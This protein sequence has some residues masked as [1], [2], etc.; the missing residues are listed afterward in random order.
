VPKGPATSTDWPARCAAYDWARVEQDLDGLGHARLPHLLGAEECRAVAALWDEPRR[1]RKHVDMGR[2]AYGEGEY[3][4][5]ANA[6]PQPVRSLRT[7]LYPPLARIANRWRERLGVAERFPARLAGLRAVCADAGQ[8]RPTPLLLRYGE[9]GYNCLHQDR[10]GEIAF[11]LQ[12]VVQL[13]PPDA[14][15][16]GDFL[17]VEQRPRRQSRG[18]AIA[19]AQGEALVFPNAER[20]VAG[21]RGFHRAAVRHGV[22]RVAAGERMTLGIL[23]HDA[24]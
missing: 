7:H 12:V 3:R 9:G 13:S 8:T 24:R 11:P 21:R 10:Y 22:A 6:I 16:G 5:F 23:F 2:H 19:L 15:A 14:Y 4:Y 20:P 18:D 17:L 1:F